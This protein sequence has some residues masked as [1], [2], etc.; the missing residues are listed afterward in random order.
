MVFG[1][2][3]GIRA[4]YLEERLVR[5]VDT[6]YPEEAA[7]IRAHEWQMYPGSVGAKT[8]RAL[9][10]KWGVGDLELTQ[11]ARKAERSWTYLSIWFVAVFVTLITVVGYALLR[12]QWR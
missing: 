6:Q 4:K 8:V 7:E 5:Y 1:A 2:L 11:R 10:D 12:R 3:L 9:P